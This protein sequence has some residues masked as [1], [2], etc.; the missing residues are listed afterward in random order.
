MLSNQIGASLHIGN[1]KT[2]AKTQ[3]EYVLLL[4]TAAGLALFIQ[5]NVMNEYL[6]L[7]ILLLLIL[8]VFTKALRKKGFDFFEPVNI[9]IGIF[10]V[11]FWVMPILRQINFKAYSLGYAIRY[12]V[13]E[14]EIKIG[15]KLSILGLLFFYLGYY[16]RVGRTLGRLLPGVP[17]K[18]HSGNILIMA[19]GSLFIGLMLW[20]YFFSQ[21]NFS[22]RY[23]FSNR[24]NIVIGGANGI[25]YHIMLLASYFGSMSLYTYLLH[26]TNLK[27][28][29]YLIPVIIAVPFIVFGGR[30]TLLIFLMSPLII[31]HYAV[32]KLA[33][34]KIVFIILIAIIFIVIFG[35]AR[36]SGSINL[37]SNFK[38]MLVFESTAQFSYSENALIA[39]HY[40]PKEK[41]FYYGQLMMQDFW[42]FLPRLIWSAKPIN[43]GSQL[44]Q[45]DT[46]PHLIDTRTGYGTYEAISPMGLGYADFGMAGAMF[47]MLVYGVFYRSIYEFF[48]HNGTFNPYNVMIY[49]LM[50]IKIPNTVRGFTGSIIACFVLWFIPLI[51][52]TKI[53]SMRIINVS[54]NA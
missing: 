10:F 22:I 1:T 29:A 52:M 18:V 35:Y 19:I 27:R 24:A 43:Y 40:Y 13:T 46:L 14:K 34:R 26:R 32:R 15:I 44:V 53:G 37:F 31:W 6:L 12:G 30:E 11:A 50:V 23:I 3:L 39:Y 41:D 45:L 47:A 9:F 16:S 25:L 28:L 8:L 2:A 54:R 38:Y 51:I 49:S 33:L 42:I 36:V 4:L 5:L 48:R 7:F 20:L 21:A 17:K